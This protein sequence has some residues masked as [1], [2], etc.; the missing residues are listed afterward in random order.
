MNGK[1]LS[2]EQKDFVRTYVA[3]GATDDEKTARRNEMAEKLGVSLPTIRAITAWTKIRQKKLL[4]EL[5]QTENTEETTDLPNQPSDQM[6]ETIIKQSPTE[7][8]LPSTTKEQSQGIEINGMQYNNETKEKWFR[9][10]LTFINSRTTPEWRARAKLITLAGPLCLRLP[11]YLSAGYRRENIIAVEGGSTEDKR[12]FQKNVPAGVQQ[13]LD[14]LENFIGTEQTKFD[15]VDYDFLGPVNDTYLDI[16]ERTALS[17]R[18]FV[19]INVMGRRESNRSQEILRFAHDDLSNQRMLRALIA[20]QKAVFEAGKLTSANDTEKAIQKG[21]D[22]VNTVFGDAED[23]ELSQARA[24]ALIS[25]FVNAVGRLRAIEGPTGESLKV[26]KEQ[27]AIRWHTEHV[28]HHALDVDLQAICTG[29]CVLVQNHLSQHGV[30]FPLPKQLGG[31]VYIARRSMWRTPLL[32]SLEKRK[33]LSENHSTPYFSFFA[34]LEDPQPLLDVCKDVE[35]FMCNFIAKSNQ[36]LVKKSKDGLL[37][38][39]VVNHTPNPLTAGLRMATQK[40]CP[41]ARG[42]MLKVSID[43]T[44]HDKMKVGQFFDQL[45]A[46]DSLLWKNWPLVDF[47]KQ[48]EVPWITINE[49]I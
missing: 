16:I 46:Y 49:K 33:Y 4:S 34:E 40:R 45:N 18:A 8:L 14:R 29:L 27:L 19:L 41:L 21:L 2:P 17:K 44:P 47:K 1:S 26:A 22:A 30:T 32:K 39:I 6:I 23:V 11:E 3:A 28:D 42:D 25:I 35:Q 37:P 9:D 20:S 13:R 15:V 43:G 10:W 24:D 12:L 38:Y 7:P 5:S 36:S 31:I 48:K